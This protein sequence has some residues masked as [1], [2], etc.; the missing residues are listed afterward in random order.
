MVS[1]T[2]AIL[3]SFSLCLCG[4]FWDSYWGLIPSVPGTVR[5][6]EEAR[7]ATVTNPRKQ[8]MKGLLSHMSMAQACFIRPQMPPDEWRAMVASATAG[9]L[10]RLPTRAPDSRTTWRTDARAVV[11]RMKIPQVSPDDVNY[12]PLAL[13]VCGLSDAD[14]R[15]ALYAYLMEDAPD[16]ADVPSPHLRS[17]ARDVERCRRAVVEVLYSLGCDLAGLQAPMPSAERIV[18]RGYA[19]MRAAQVASLEGQPVMVVK[20]LRRAAGL[21]VEVGHMLPDGAGEWGQWLDTAEGA[22]WVPESRAWGAWLAEIEP[23]PTEEN[24]M[25]AEASERGRAFSPPVTGVPDDHAALMEAGSQ[26]LKAHGVNV[27]GLDPNYHGRGIVPRDPAGAEKRAHALAGETGTTL[28]ALRAKSRAARATVDW[29]DAVRVDIAQTL[30]R[31]GFATE[32]IA[33]ILGRSLS[34]VKEWC[35]GIKTPKQSQDERTTESGED[36]DS[37]RAMERGIR[38]EMR[39]EGLL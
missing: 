36:L 30:K 32:D 38:A 11:L 22:K 15:A 14:L 13:A 26:F 16:F 9:R 31:E 5:A 28:S 7:L 39:R 27:T 35:K 33:T 10:R 1:V 24:I 23:V 18:S 6:A 19:G 8:E 29:L 4:R 25:D 21:P 37:I 20:A 17:V 2:V 3:S 12:A 34:T